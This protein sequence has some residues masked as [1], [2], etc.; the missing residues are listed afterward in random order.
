MGELNNIFK[1]LDSLHNSGLHLPIG[2]YRSNPIPSILNLTN[3]P[4]LKIR[5]L[6]LTLNQE[7][8]LATSI[9]EL[10]FTPNFSNLLPLLH[11]NNLVLSDLTPNIPS[12]FPPWVPFLNLNRY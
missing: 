4:P 8:K 11:D 2:A 5:R 1:K 6:Q 12:I 3:V 10:D 9:A 7:L